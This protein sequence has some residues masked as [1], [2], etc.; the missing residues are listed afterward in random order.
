M[1]VRESYSRALEQ[2]T[3]EGSGRLC[4]YT[5]FHYRNLP[6]VRLVLSAVT[7]SLHYIR[8]IVERH[9]YC[10]RKRGLHFEMD[11][12]PSSI[13]PPNPTMVLCERM[14][15]Q[16]QQMKLKTIQTLPLALLTLCGVH[17]V[18]MLCLACIQRLL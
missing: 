4:S 1:N 16:H 15:E 12:N 9:L 8:Q 14:R 10:V 2:G 11:F 3:L 17:S 6:R 18:M 5:L 7:L 13:L